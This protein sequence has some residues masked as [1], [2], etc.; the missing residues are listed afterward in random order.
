M[1]DTIDVENSFNS[2]QIFL[3]EKIGNEWYVVNGSD[4]IVVKEHPFEIV[5]YS[6]KPVDFFRES[7]NI[8]EI[9]KKITKDRIVKSAVRKFPGLRIL[10]QDPFQCYITFILSSNS[11]I[12]NIKRMLHRLCSK[13]GTKIQYKDKNFCLFPEPNQLVKA[14]KNELRECGLGY[15]TKSVKIGT[16]AVISGEIDFDFL[17]KTDYYT[18]KDSLTKIFGIGN[19]I[20]DCVL[21]FSLEKLEAFPLDRWILRVLEKYYSDK[22]KDTKTITEKRYKNL[23]EE[24]VK[25]FG[26]Y[27]GYS[28]QYLFKMERELNQKKWL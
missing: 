25:Y 14:Q 12:Q 11:N 26:P 20:A 2:G 21:L 28:Q 3:W 7:D 19:K 13:F 5:S 23:H 4:V 1:Y 27:A 6:N 24:I 17:K 8:T 22:F 18:A 9:F 10:R 15:R 16:D